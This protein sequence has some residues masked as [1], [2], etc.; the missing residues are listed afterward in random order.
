[1]DLD[2]L[3]GPAKVPR[4]VKY[5][6][7]APVKKVKKEVLP[8][9][10]NEE[11]GIDEAKAEYL[12][13]R[14]HETS[15]GR[16][17]PEKKVVSAQLAQVAFGVGEASTFKSYHP[18]NGT[19]SDGKSLERIP[20]VGK[21]YKEPWNYYSNYPVTLP[22]RRPYAGN[23]EILDK[24]EF[25][26]D[27]GTPVPEENARNAAQELGLLDKSPE[28]NMFFLQLPK[29]LPGIAQLADPEAP[30]SQN[31]TTLDSLPQGLIGKMLVYKS[32][33]VKMKIGNAI[34]NVT[35]GMKCMFSQDVVAI[36]AEKKLCC[37][38]GELN[39]RAVAT[40][41]VDSMLQGMTDL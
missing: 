2:P 3:A 14:L 31:L 23:P 25:D 40:L 41:D 35:A 38:L 39:K 19:S 30:E 27:E 11:D 7:K 10:E 1:M 36:T 8:K 4:K 20:K 34:Y 17:K 9:V 6:P 28:N 32:G 26:G 16:P 5:K 18:S 12:L 29:M 13:R 21:E 22:I 24:E 33:A 15:S 37:N